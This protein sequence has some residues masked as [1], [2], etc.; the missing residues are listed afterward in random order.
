M[1]GVVVVVWAIGDGTCDAF[2]T[3]FP[4][5]WNVGDG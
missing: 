5:W 4:G 2:E 3:G 1:P